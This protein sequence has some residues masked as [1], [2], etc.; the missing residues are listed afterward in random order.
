MNFAHSAAQN[1]DEGFQF[2]GIFNVIRTCSVV[3]PFSSLFFYLSS[4]VLEIVQTGCSWIA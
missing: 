1:A 2:H 4:F 3:M